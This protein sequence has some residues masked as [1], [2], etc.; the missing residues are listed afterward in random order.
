M[1]TDTASDETLG[2]GVGPLSGLV[3]IETGSMISAPTTGRLL[4]DFGATVVKVEYPTAGDHSRRF[5]PVKDEVGLWWKYVGRNKKSI[6][7]DLK[8]TEGQEVLLDLVSEA[9]V[10]LENFR[11]GTLERWNLGFDRLKEVNSDLIVMRISGFGQDGPYAERPGFGTLAEAMSG[12]AYINGYP[13]RPPLL[14]PT[15]LA[16]HIAGLFGVIGVM[17]A[18]YHRDVNDGGG[19]YIDVSLIEPI[20]NI[21]GPQ[22]LRY[23]QLGEIEERSG[24]RSTNSAPRNVYR[25]SDGRYVA[26]AGSAQPLAM[27]VFD[28]I[29]RPDLK[30]DPRFVDNE[31]RVKHY[32]ELDAVIGDWI[33]AHTR[34]EVL[35]AFEASDATLVPVYNIK[36]IM[37]DPHYKAR[38]SVVRVDDPDFGEAAVQNV[39]PRF[40]ESPGKI[41]HLGVHL[42]AHNDLVYREFLGYDS[43][44]LAELEDTG[45]I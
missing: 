30:D 35:E 39:F 17:Y 11:P 1:S 36:D 40:S 22:P 42:G 12:F 23:D 33:G 15:G 19:Q 7:L 38:Q 16:D 13:D 3:V 34:Q 26:L 4:A 28:A 20:F 8:A 45:V 2:T 6:T 5:G 31:S 14:P 25:T 41:E 32:D 9:D 37:H 10:L 43:E 44:M 21:L 18:L 27:R 29:Q 24:N